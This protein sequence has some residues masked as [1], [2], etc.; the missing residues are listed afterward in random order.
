MLYTDQITENVPYVPDYHL[1]HLSLVA[2]PLSPPATSR[3][4][5]FAAFVI[6]SEGSS[7]YVMNVC[8]ETEKKSLDDCCRFKQIKLPISLHTY[9]STTI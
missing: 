6:I 9:H 3:G 2:W 8:S 4:N 1:I 7:G 5:F